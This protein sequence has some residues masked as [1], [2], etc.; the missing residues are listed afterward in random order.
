MNHKLTTSATY[1][2][3]RGFTLVEMLVTVSIMAVMVATFGLVLER[4]QTLVSS[5]QEVMK[6]NSAA[7]TVSNIIRKDLSA[8]SKK[9]FLW[10]PTTGTGATADLII[11]NP[12]E[13][14][15]AFSPARG[16]GRIVAYGT[17][18]D[19]ATSAS[20]DAFWRR[21]RIL[22]T[23]AVQ[24]GGNYPEDVFTYSSPAEPL[25]FSGLQQG[26]LVNYQRAAPANTYVYTY[27]NSSI[28]V[29][30]A[31]GTLTSE[32][33]SVGEMENLSSLLM[34]GF[35]SSQFSI[36]AIQ[37]SR[38]AGTEGQFVTATDNLWHANT[39][40]NP[41]SPIVDGWPEFLKIKFTID[42]DTIGSIDY[43]ILCPIN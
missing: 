24:L 22:T 29:D 17:G 1:S 42:S 41:S 3:R 10:I 30:A 37:V 27:L 15:S 20:N 2:A 28:N 25:D 9:G 21:T 8:V 11:G 18:D 34:S 26:I 23:S 36:T 5:A 12:G 13:Y 38:A 35:D 6:A 32:P 7:L 16:T 14:H 19:Q 43:E 40:E 39:A 4:A 31:P 33:E